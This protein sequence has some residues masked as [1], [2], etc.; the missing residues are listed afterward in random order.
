M[1]HATTPTADRTCA[2]CG[3]EYRA[4]R[5]AWAKK[6]RLRCNVGGRAHQWTVGI[7]DA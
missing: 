6:R 1:R 5:K 2:Y 4:V 3:V 7:H